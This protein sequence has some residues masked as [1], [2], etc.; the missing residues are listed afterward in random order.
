[1]FN[2][3]ILFVH[4]FC[5]VKCYLRRISQIR[6]MKKCRVKRV[7]ARGPEIPTDLTKE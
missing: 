4:I 1:M 5:G 3:I 2:C 7:V 6:M